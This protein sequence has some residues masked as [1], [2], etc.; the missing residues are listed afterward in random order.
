MLDTTAKIAS[1]VSVVVGLA[2]SVGGYFANAKLQAANLKLQSLQESIGKLT[3]AD[4]EMDVAKKAYDL[5][6][7]LTTDFAVPLARSF[8]IQYGQKDRTSQHVSFPTSP[9]LQEFTTV[10]G[11]WES[12]RGLMT[13]KACEQE[14]LKARQVVTLMVRNIG[15]ADARR[16]SIKARQKSS[17]LPDPTAR[18]QEM[19]AASKPLGYYDLL[20]ATTGW[21]TIEVPM[22]DLR[23]RSSPETERVQEQVVLAS[24]S[25]TTALFGTVLVPMEI[26]WTDDITR[27]TQS[28]KVLDTHAA[29]L[30]AELMGAEIGSLGSACR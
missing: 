2:I 10:L 21:S 29:M 18:W 15:H 1:V 17:P 24:V 26:S 9:L 11:G 14:G 28:L 5:S 6:A 22:P 30:R 7:R 27:T 25:G 19:S 4:K 8:A 3:V 16:V 12:R 13:G 20:S 23:G